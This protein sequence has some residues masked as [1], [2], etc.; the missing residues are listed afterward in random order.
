MYGSTNCVDFDFG[1]SAC[2]STVCASV[3]YTCINDTRVTCQQLTWVV[4]YL[5][6]RGQRVLV[7]G[8]R[9]M[10][11]WQ[12]DIMARMSASC[13]IFLCDDV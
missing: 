2:L 13:Q 9:H 10:S 12:R 3:V 5:A 11:K 8:R 7:L 1:R 6:R 4:E